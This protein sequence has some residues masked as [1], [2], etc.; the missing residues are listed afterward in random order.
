MEDS[1]ETASLDVLQAP[2]PLEVTFAK[3]VA[4]TMGRWTRVVRVILKHNCPAD[5]DDVVQDALGQAWKGLESF[6]GRSKLETWLHSIMVNAART[7]LDRQKRR[8]KHVA[9]ADRHSVDPNDP[10]SMLTDAVT[11]RKQ[12]EQSTLVWKLIT[13]LRRQHRLPL[14]LLLAGIPKDSIAGALALS[15]KQVDARIDYA[16]HQIIEAIAKGRY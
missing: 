9:L 3:L 2:E 10:F 12:D 4:S 1:S 13:G 14:T 15:K 16:R 8:K 5:V 7:F 6:D 11:A